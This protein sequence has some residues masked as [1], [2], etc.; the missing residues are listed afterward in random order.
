M[1]A[2][3]P[4]RAGCSNRNFARKE[5]RLAERLR[6]HLVRIGVRPGPF[7]PAGLEIPRAQRMVFPTRVD[8]RTTA[9]C[10]QHGNRVATLPMST[11]WGRTLSMSTAWCCA[12]RCSTSKHNGPQLF[13]PSRRKTYGIAVGIV[14]H[15]NDVVPR[16]PKRTVGSCLLVPGLVSICAATR[17]SRTQRWQM[18]YDPSASIYQCRQFLD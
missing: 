8:L 13:G 9:K 16:R 7:L 15:R 14:D 1:E 12:W 4:A 2:I 6:Q 11:A 3:Q 10:G 17:R 18:M 5:S